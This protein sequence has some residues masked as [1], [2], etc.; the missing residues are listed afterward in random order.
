M[1]VVMKIPVLNSKL[2][3]IFKVSVKED[4][5][6]TTS[7]MLHLFL[8]LIYNLHRKAKRTLEQFHLV[9]LT[10]MTVLEEFMITWC[11]TNK[12]VGCATPYTTK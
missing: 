5:H 8:I 12:R 4:L 10:V 1:T 6:T 7:Q 9:S 3:N 11:G 2:Y